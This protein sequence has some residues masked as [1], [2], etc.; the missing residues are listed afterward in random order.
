MLEGIA[1]TLTERLLQD[2]AGIGARE[3]SKRVTARVATS[4]RE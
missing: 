2:N 3:I 1:K 4:D